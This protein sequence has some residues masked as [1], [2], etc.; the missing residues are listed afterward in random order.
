MAFEGTWLYNRS[1]NLDAFMEKLG[2]SEEARALIRKA[3]P[4]LEFEKTEDGA[5]TIKMIGEKKTIVINAKRN[6]EYDSP[7]GVMTD[8]TRKVRTEKISDTK[9]VT[10][11]TGDQSQLI[12]RVVETREIIDGELLTTYEVDGVTCKR[13]FKRA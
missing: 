6:E 13:Y 3:K 2:A 11:G 10:K 1:E 4:K 12:N 9:F 8:K 5:G 7:T